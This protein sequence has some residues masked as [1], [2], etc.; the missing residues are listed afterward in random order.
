MQ[1]HISVRRNFLISLY[2]T[3]SLFI[4]TNA[5]AFWPGWTTDIVES[6]WTAQGQLQIVQAGVDG[7]GIMVQ[8]QLLRELEA[9]WV[10]I[11]DTYPAGSSPD[12][13]LLAIGTG[14]GSCSREYRLLDLSPG[15]NPY[16]SGEFGNCSEVPVLQ[17]Q[18]NGLRIEFPGWQG[19]KPQTWQYE[20]G[21]GVFRP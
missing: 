6:R 16:L 15:H 11:Q 4:A 8:G 21:K 13:L 5:L 7:Y 20:A 12:Y 3:V 18:G 9:F 14:G 10:T 19:A 17:A 1:L 2:A